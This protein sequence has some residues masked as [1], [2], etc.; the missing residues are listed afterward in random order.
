MDGPFRIRKAA[1]G[2][3]L[4]MQDLWECETEAEEGM[5]TGTYHTI[6][7]LFSAREHITRMS[8]KSHD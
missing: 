2:V 5:R 3:V 7:L 8:F 6:L 1:Y 4:A